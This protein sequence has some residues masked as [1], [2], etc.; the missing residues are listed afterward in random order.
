MELWS[1]RLNRSKLK[2]SLECVKT[3]R[4]NLITF[5]DK[6]F[7]LL[8]N[9]ITLYNLHII[10]ECKSAAR[11]NYLKRFQCHLVRD[12]HPDKSI[13]PDNK[14]RRFGSGGQFGATK[15]IRFVCVR[16]VM[17]ARSSFYT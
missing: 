8:S 3:A 15:V 11:R 4:A 12:A 1:V 10:Y 6:T 14:V 5:V 16:L 2:T 13:Y 9:L 7:R 17:S